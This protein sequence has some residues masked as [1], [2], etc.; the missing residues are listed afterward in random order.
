MAEKNPVDQHSRLENVELRTLYQTVEELDA[1]HVTSS[2]YHANNTYENGWG[3]TEH[4]IRDMQRL[5]KK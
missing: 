4:D 1:Q 3:D 2:S 5:G